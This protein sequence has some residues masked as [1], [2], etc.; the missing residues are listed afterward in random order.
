MT[1]TTQD[2]LIS[3]I[4]ANNQKIIE[5]Y[6]KLQ[7]GRLNIAPEFQRKLVWRRQHK[8]EFIETI[9]KNFPFPE[10]YL[11]PEKVDTDKLELKEMVVDGQQ[12]LTAIQEYIAGQ[13]VFSQPATIPRFVELTTTQKEDFLNYEIS[14]RYLKNASPQQI[15]EIFQRINRTDYSLN[16]MERFHAA[17]GDS[18]LLCLAKQL[19]DKDLEINLDIVDFRVPNDQR[20]WLLEFFG[21]GLDEGVF[22]ESE[23]NRMFSLQY[24]LVLL[25][26]LIQANYF[27]RNTLIEEAV[28][29]YNEQVPDAEQL[30][31]RLVETT[32]FISALDLPKNSIWSTKS[33]L[34]SLIV[35]TYQ[36]SINYI[37]ATKLASILRAVDEDIKSEISTDEKAKIYYGYTREAVNEKRARDFRGEYI[38]NILTACNIP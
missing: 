30:V 6:Q 26:T 8:I 29:T 7:T 20:G 34:F 5:I 15:K 31:N 11:A 38:R 27:H 36:L 19:I 14:V 16:R 37:N 23:V 35:E 21:V 1:P 4:P 13:G 3:S 33:S 24:I 10:V 2:K 17:W 25:V 28:K 18:E 9:L 12:R 32:K 22:S